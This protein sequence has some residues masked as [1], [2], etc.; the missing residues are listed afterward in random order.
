MYT[1][2]NILSVGATDTQLSV[3]TAQQL[4]SVQ[5]V[6]GSEKAEES[7]SEGTARCVHVLLLLM[8][9]HVAISGN[10]SICHVDACIGMVQQ[11]NQLMQDCSYA[12]A[13]N[14]P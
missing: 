8:H 9:I 12:A 13:F 1:L 3:C 10:D 5:N 11:I 7:K 14:M 4:A 2:E 6:K